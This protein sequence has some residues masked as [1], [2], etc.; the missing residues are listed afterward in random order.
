[1][2]CHW[3][4]LLLDFGSFLTNENW[5]M[6]NENSLLVN[7][8]SCDQFSATSSCKKASLSLPL[9]Y[10]TEKGLEQSYWKQDDGEESSA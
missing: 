5:A 7:W 8:A 9:Y 1:M 2:D 10:C 3:G 4:Q 6:K